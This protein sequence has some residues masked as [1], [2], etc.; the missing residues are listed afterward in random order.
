MPQVK[1]R[2]GRSRPS[3]AQPASAQPNR[4]ILVLP[5][6]DSAAPVVE[7][8]HM[9]EVDARH[10]DKAVRPIRR[11]EVAS[12]T[13]ARVVA[14]H[15]QEPDIQAVSPHATPGR[16]TR[17]SSIS[18]SRAARPRRVAEALTEHQ[19]LRRE[20]PAWLRALTDRVDESPPWDAV[21]VEEY[22]VIAA[23]GDCGSIER[24]RLAK[25][26]LGLPDVA[27]VSVGPASGRRPFPTDPSD[28]SSATTTSSSWPSLP[29]EGMEHHVELLRPLVSGEDDRDVRATG[30]HFAASM[31]PTPTS[32]ASSRSPSTASSRELD[33]VS[34]RSC[35]LE[36]VWPFRSA[37][38][39]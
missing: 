19:P 4:E 33:S 34:S 32:I 10:S 6:V 14:G 20:E 8:V 25:A 28:P 7:P 17:R 2:R 5:V 15:A 27:D 13:G 30:A 11:H 36:L 9:F 3:A 23:G 1:H 35:R 29:R 12:T 18:I 37:C 21:C 16:A 22:E 38:Q 31:P 24:T 26:V 39:R